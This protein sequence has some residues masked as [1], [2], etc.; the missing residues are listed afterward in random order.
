[1]TPKQTF[2]A[3]QRIARE[4]GRAVQELLTLYLLE[5]FLAR[6]VE[7]SYADSFVLK[8]GVLLAG[9]GLRRPTRDVDMQAIDFVLDE[10]HCRQVLAEVTATAADDGVVLDAI[11]TRIEQIRDEEQY[12]GLRIHVTAKLHRAQIALKLDISTGDPISPHTQLV[13]MPRILGGEFTLTGHPPKTVIAEKAVTVLQR[14]ATSARWRDYMDIRFLSQAGAS[15]RRHCAKRSR[16][17]RSTE[18]SS[19]PRL[20]PR[21]PDTMTSHNRNGQHGAR[22]RM[23]GT[24]LC[25]SS[26][27]NSSNCA[28]SSTRYSRASS[29]PEPNGIR[30]RGSGA[31]T[32]I[33]ELSAADRGHRSRT[34]LLLGDNDGCDHRARPVAALHPPRDRRSH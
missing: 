27:I 1:M 14:G 9:Y 33:S 4:Q 15:K 18:R 8:G 24:S 16:K 23:L 10:E 34:Y 17:S 30:F 32:T 29:V 3:L 19:S 28:D 6:L 31:P 2:N 13:T 25:P 21:S 5:R 20:Q 26:A 12:S 7:S 22:R 11:P